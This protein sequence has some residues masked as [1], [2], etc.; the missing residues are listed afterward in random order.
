MAVEAVAVLE[1]AQEMLVAVAAA[2]VQVAQAHKVLKM[3]K[4]MAAHL[5]LTHLTQTAN[6]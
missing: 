6:R 1:A 4:V 3:L 5:A 2:V